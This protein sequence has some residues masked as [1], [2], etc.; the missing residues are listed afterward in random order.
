MP[1]HDPYMINTNVVEAS[2]RAGVRKLTGMSDRMDWDAS[3][4]NGQTTGL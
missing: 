1:F 3:K 4:P 2:R